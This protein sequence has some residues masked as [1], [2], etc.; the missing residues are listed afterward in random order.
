M[1]L[2][3]FQQAIA[4]VGWAVTGPILDV[5]A[6]AHLRDRLAPLTHTGRGG[7]RNL[8]DDP[9][10]AALA[11]AP[12]LR[13]FAAVVLGNSCF[14]VRALFF[15]K[16]PDANW[17]VVWHQDLTIAAQQR[18]DVPGY[19]PWTEKGGVPHVQPPIDVLER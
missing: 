18:V 17:K 14:T 16:T 7:G 9:H 19:G 12:A 8:L 13:Q 2:L 11:A 3:S 4:T 5:A 1:D 15:D 10:I 6:I